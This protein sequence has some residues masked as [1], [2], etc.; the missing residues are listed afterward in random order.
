MVNL[1]SF[2]L[3]WL[4]G[5]S[6]A[7]GWSSDLILDP[8]AFRLK[9]TEERKITWCFSTV[10]LWRGAKLLHTSAPLFAFPSL[11]LAWCIPCG[12]GQSVPNLQEDRSVTLAAAE[13][14]FGRRCSNKLLLQHFSCFPPRRP[15]RVSHCFPC[16]R[17][18]GAGARTKVNGS[19]SGRGGGGG[20]SVKSS[21]HGGGEWGGRAGAPLPCHSP[22]PV[23]FQVRWMS[24]PSIIPQSRG[25]RN[26]LGYWNLLA[27][28]G[29]ALLAWRLLF[30]G[31]C[32]QDLVIY[33]M[34]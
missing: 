5:G 9:V 12:V 10:C 15:R 1:F 2:L 25:G 30:C 4:K 6:T 19:R 34:D 20:G 29:A 23:I 16:S 33:I 17:S 7:W 18:D 31:L 32:C 27:S 3:V 22:G 13:P 14:G 11:Y 21:S 24:V 8:Q 28:E 26:L